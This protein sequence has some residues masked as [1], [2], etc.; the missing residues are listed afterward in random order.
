[1]TDHAILTRDE[2]VDHM[3]RTGLF[4]A[5]AENCEHDPRVW[6]HFFKACQDRVQF[7]VEDTVSVHLGKY[8]FCYEPLDEDR[9]GLN[10]ALV[11]PMVD[12]FLPVTW[13][14]FIKDLPTLQESVAGNIPHNVVTDTFGT[15]DGFGVSNP[16]TIRLN[17]PV[18][19]IKPGFAQYLES[20][21]GKRRKKHRHLLQDFDSPDFRFE[22]SNAPLTTAEIDFAESHLNRRWGDDAPYALIQ[23]LWSQSCA[24]IRPE[25]ALFMRV[26]NKDLLIFVQTLLIRGGGVY[27]QS[28]FKNEDVFFD[29]IAPYTDFKCIE[30]LCGSPHGFLDPSCRSSLDDP[31]SIGIAKRATVNCNIT[32]PLLVLGGSLPENVAEALSSPGALGDEV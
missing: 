22:L 1:M 26:Y 13:D 31:A 25:K 30:A 21:N 23:T 16:H 11:T 6:R 19:A 9:P 5:S 17:S 3:E 20:L 8:G 12:P 28:I 7:Q 14:Q 24:T 27:C 4:F 29:G 2:Y 15:L 18:A 32:K 10:F